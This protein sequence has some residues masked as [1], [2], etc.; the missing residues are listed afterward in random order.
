MDF[1]IGVSWADIQVLL[2]RLA[3]SHRRSRADRYAGIALAVVLAAT[4]S[5]VAVALLRD[6]KIVARIIGAGAGV[7]GLL[8][9]VAI[10]AEQYDVYDISL[11]GIDKLS[12]FAGR[13]W[14][15]EPEMIFTMSLRFTDI[16]FLKIKLTSDQTRFVP[17][18]GTLRSALAELYPEIGSGQSR[19]LP[20]KVGNFFYALLALVV[21]GTAVLLWVLAAKGLLRWK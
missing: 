14:H 13:S 4:V 8:L 21:L 6:G 18:F 3:G 2:Q 16:W 20:A 10:V 7:L 5:F 11:K 1:E 15:V 17:L 9:G 12:P 19:R